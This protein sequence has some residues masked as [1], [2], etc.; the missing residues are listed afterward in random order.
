MRVFGPDFTFPFDDWVAHP[1]GIGSVP[2]EATGTRVGI[3]GAGVAGMVAAHELVRLGLTPVVYEAARIGGRLRSERFRP[4]T[5]HSEQHVDPII[6]ELGGMRFPRSGS[7]FFHYVDRCALDVQPFPNPLTEAAPTTV[8]DLAGKTYFA[9]TADDLPEG[10]G[11][12]AAAWAEA[13]DTHA[14][15]GDIQAAMRDRDASAV[16][17]IWNP[18]VSAW[19][20][21]TFYDFVATSDSFSRLSFRHREVFGQVGFGT[22]GWDSD[23]PNSMLEILRVVMSDF[24]EDQHFIVGGAERLPRRIWGL[25]VEHPAYHPP[26]TSVADLHPGG[27]TRPGVTALARDGDQIEVT[28]RWGNTE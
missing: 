24:E 2:A 18:I 13:L 21:R 27:S 19:D 9:R 8:I 7:S 22:G 14:S 1:A 28:D 17:E 3:V 15:L 6:A 16:K 23:F 10:F 5:A 26:G 12:V 4:G 20:D 25:P 11:E